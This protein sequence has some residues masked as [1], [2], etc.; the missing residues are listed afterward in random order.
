MLHLFHSSALKL[1]LLLRLWVKL[2]FRLFSPV[3]VAGHAIVLA[4]GFKAPKEGKKMPSVKSLH[5]ESADN[6]KPEYIMG[7]SF[8]VISL[9]VAGRTNQFFAVPL[10][11]RIHEGLV[12]SNRDHR[13]LLDKLAV[14]FIEVAQIADRPLMLCADAYYASRKVIVPL[15]AA[16]HHLLA[17][18][19]INCVAYLPNVAKNPGKRGRPKLYGEKVCLRSL[20]AVND[21]W[22]S[23]PSPVYSEKNVV[24]RFKSIRLLWRPVGHLVQFVLIEHPTR[25]SIILLCT[26][27]TLDPL[28]VIRIYGL[29]YNSQLAS[30]YENGFDPFRNGG[31]SGTQIKPAGISLD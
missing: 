17:K 16:G 5:Q 2:A 27:L 21:G 26:M 22:A 30:N 13:S 23:A 11:S 1:D 29:R 15:L 4:D 3:V 8:Q 28:M 14:M 18:V 24:I 12:F 6:T 25:G 7:H 19:K 31:G 9:L 10:V 20:F